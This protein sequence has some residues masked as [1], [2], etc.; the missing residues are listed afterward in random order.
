MRRRGRIPVTNASAHR[1][2]GESNAA[3]TW[4]ALSVEDVAES[5]TSDSYE[6]LTGAEAQARLERDG[7]NRLRPPEGRSAV[8][9]LVAQFRSLIMLLLLVAVG[10]ALALGETFEAYAV[11]V[12]IV[13][14]T[15]IGFLTEL[16]AEKAMQ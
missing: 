4:H 11:L 7:P 6:G 12:V 15:L 5:L 10:L 1:K 16:R 3:A 14:N 9:I 13:I 2:P 8:A